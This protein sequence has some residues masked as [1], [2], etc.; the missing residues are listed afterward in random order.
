MNELLRFRWEAAIGDERI[1]AK[2]LAALAKHK[3]P[4][5]RFRGAWVAVDPEELAA[6]RRRIAEGE[7]AIPVREAVRA[8]LA[9]EVTERG[10]RASVVAEGLVARMLAVARAAAD[11]PA[12]APP[13][14]RATLRPY[15]ERG[16]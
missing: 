14:L 11:V 13:G 8:A 12:S 15:Q 3:A 5:V 9:G 10:L 7:Q 1:G 16:L 6:I 2:E 4:L